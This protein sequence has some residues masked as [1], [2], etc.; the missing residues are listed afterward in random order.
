MDYKY[1]IIHNYLI[2]FL[3]NNYMM[4]QINNPKIQRMNHNY[5]HYNYDD[6]NEILKMLKMEYIKIFPMEKHNQNVLI[7][8]YIL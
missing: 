8:F 4:F 1:L 2:S 6:K 5:H 7:M 3:Y